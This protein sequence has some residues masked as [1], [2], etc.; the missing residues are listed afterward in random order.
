[1]L[2][3]PDIIGTEAELSRLANEQPNLSQLSLQG[4]GLT[5]LE[6]L[7]RFE[8]LRC[9]SI[10]GMYHSGSQPN[11]QDT[12]RDFSALA[13]LPHLEDL[14]VHDCRFFDNAALEF[15]TQAPCLRKFGLSTFMVTVTD[16]T[17]LR[18]ANQLRELDI[19]AYCKW[20]F[21]R[22]FWNNLLR[23]FHCELDRQIQELRGLLPNCKIITWF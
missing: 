13:Q 20:H 11:H 14:Y 15:L 6:T 12:V 17:L 21:H 5:S 8:R 18:N 10:S 9:L 16:L 23:G 7:T 19:R 2:C 3:Y 22:S 4:F 1:M